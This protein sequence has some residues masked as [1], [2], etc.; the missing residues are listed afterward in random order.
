MTPLSRSTP[1]PKPLS[2]KDNGNTR[3]STCNFLGL[4]NKCIEINWIILSVL[5]AH[6]SLSISFTHC[7][8]RSLVYSPSFGVQRTTVSCAESL[9]TGENSRG[10]TFVSVAFINQGSVGGRIAPSTLYSLPPG[11]KHTDEL[12][13]TSQDNTPTSAISHETIGKLSTTTTAP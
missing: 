7:C 12:A 3:Q 13:N 5:N 9:A 10:W 1:T 8:I 6:L 4:L 2:M 11:I